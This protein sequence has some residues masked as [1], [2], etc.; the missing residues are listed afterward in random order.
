MSMLSKS[1]SNTTTN[2]FTEAIILTRFNLDSEQQKIQ[3]C[4]TKDTLFGP[5]FVDPFDVQHPVNQAFTNYQV[6][7]MREHNKKYTTT[8]KLESKKPR[9]SSP[10]KIE[11]RSKRRNLNRTD[12]DF[13]LER[14]MSSE[15]EYILPSHTHNSKPRSNSKTTDGQPECCLVGCS[16]E[17]NN[18]LRFSL[19]THEIQDFKSEFVERGW[20]KVCHYHYF[21][22]LYKFKKMTN[23]GSAKPLNP[24]RG[25]PKKK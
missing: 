1:K 21:S 4:Q 9:L 3:Q 17:V 8:Q 25:A 5:N 11:K 14:D 18:R 16:N 23:G 24:K 19:R 7:L 20:D 12:D 10:E 22:D 15:D 2:A 13:Y 6:Y